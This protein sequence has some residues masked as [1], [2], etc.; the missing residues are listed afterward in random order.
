MIIITIAKNMRNHYHDVRD[1][2]HDHEGQVHLVKEGVDSS[3]MDIDMMIM[4]ML[5]MLTTTKSTWSKRGWTP[6]EWTSTSDFH[7]EQSIAEL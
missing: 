7:S 2:D 3:M 5:M 1:D 6:P 4:K